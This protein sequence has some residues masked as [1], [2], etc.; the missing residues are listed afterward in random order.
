MLFIVF[1]RG[2]N[3]S[4][5]PFHVVDTQ[6]EI[7]PNTYD[8][9]CEIKMRSVPVL[10]IVPRDTHPEILPTRWVLKRE[11]KV[12]TQAPCIFLLLVFSATWKEFSSNCVYIF[13]ISDP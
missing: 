7:Q 9:V 3:V 10:S 12:G 1:M 11:A 13:D 2:K 4:L 5:L 6:R 8:G